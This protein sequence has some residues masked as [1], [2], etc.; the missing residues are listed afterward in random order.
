MFRIRRIHDDVL[1]RNRHAIEAVQHMWREQFP[2]VREET[3]TALTEQLRDPVAHQFRTVVLVAES[4]DKVV[5]F[6]I[7]MHAPDLRFC[8][9][10]FITAGS[11]AEGRGIGGALYE[12]ARE[13]SRALSALGLFYE[14]LP[15]E[16][17]ELS[18]P[19]LLSQNAARLRFYER[20]NARPII[21]TRYTDPIK[22]GDKDLPY[23]VFDDLDTGRPL[24]KKEAQAIVRA[25]LERKYDWLCPPEYI[26]RVVSS[27][28][29]DP[30]RLRAPR[31]AKPR[32]APRKITSLDLRLAFC[33]SKDHAFHHVR[34]RG[35]VEAPV[36][37]AAIQRELTHLP[38]LHPMATRRFGIEHIARVHDADFLRYLERVCRR[39]PEDKSVYPYVFPVRNQ[40]RP[41]SDMEVRAGYFCIDTFTPL[42]KNVW[43]AARAAVDCALTA[44]HALLSGARLS[45]ALVRP[46]GHHAER[47][48]FG[49]FCYLNNAAV[50]AE[51]LSRHGSVAMLDIDYHHGNGQQEIFYARSDVLTVSL[52][53]DPS[54]AY[55]YF[56][57][58]ADE[59]GEGEGA[60]FN[61]NL[62]L[63]EKL[64]GKGYLKHLAGA[65]ALLG[66][67]GPRFLVVCLGL[68]TAR[69]DPTGTWSLD[70]NRFAAGGPGHRQALAPHLGGPGGR[71]PDPTSRHQRA[72]LLYGLVGREHRANAQLR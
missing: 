30:V 29:D 24:R 40:A 60:G 71:L 1:P 32:A 56:S 14:C 49:G 3:F 4:R 61:V 68:D 58:F 51:F 13:E 5:G 7:L 41:P 6:A 36:R 2:G 37:V 23:L 11:G 38:I 9:L 63:P 8:Y 27:F 22:P 45:Y 64:D 10:D 34:E 48:V 42:T 65:L 69:G 70:P 20:Y 39:L 72:P 62:P 33:V 26:E 47:R 46:P 50:A 52:H 16:A 66:D 21:N 55:P 12:R 31:Y 53:G 54:F 18:D 35:Y 44:A 57:G 19:A 17:S 25:I 15:D 67:F 59:R 28:H 43:H